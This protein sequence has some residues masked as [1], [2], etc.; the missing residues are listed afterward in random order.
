M[1]VEFKQA[2]IDEFDDIQE[3]MKMSFSDISMNYVSNPDLLPPG[4]DDGSY[5]KKKIPEG[6]IINIKLDDEIVGGYH[7]LSYLDNQK[8]MELKLLWISTN[9]QN[10]GLGSIAW[11]HIEKTYKTDVWWVLTPKFALSN[12]RFYE[13]LGF[14]KVKE[15]EDPDVIL[16][17][18]RKNL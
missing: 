10:K 12:H 14:K 7:V 6:S 4:M 5:L 8:D 9:H 18:Y 2:T 11:Q 3:K 16:I 15:M 13:K 1:K 17:L